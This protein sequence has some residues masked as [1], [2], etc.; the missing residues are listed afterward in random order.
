MAKKFT[1]DLLIK[2]VYHETSIS[3]KLDIEDELHSNFELREYYQMLVNAYQTLP[4]VSF[5]P[6][7]AAINQILK[8]SQHSPLEAGF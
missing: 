4:K 1:L 7:Q 2:Y 5:N 6:P 8:Y 3:E